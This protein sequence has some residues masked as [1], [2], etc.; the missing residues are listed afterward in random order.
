MGKKTFLHYRKRRYHCSNCQKHFYESFPLLPKHCRITTRL[1]FYAIHLLKS[2][3]NVRSTAAHLG[4]YDSFIFRRMRDVRYPKPSLLPRVL[5]IDEFKGNSGGQKFQAILTDPKAHKVFDILPSR[6][7]VSLM[8][9]L[10]E[11]PNKKEVRYFVT[12]M[13]QVYRDLAKAYFPK[14][15][16]VIDKFHVVRYVTW[17]LENVRK[18][19]QKQLHP[20]KRKYFKRSR[21][22]LLTHKR[23]LNRESLEALEIMLIHSQ[24]LAVAYHLKELFYEFMESKSKAEAIPKLRTGCTS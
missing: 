11:F 18:R 2:R 21:K 23:K 8:Q 24:D 19:V 6:A 22:L 3:Q 4:V 5:S 7:Q 13:N 17:A 14:A 10:N 12:D 1:A 9:Y 20:S 15:V 16:I